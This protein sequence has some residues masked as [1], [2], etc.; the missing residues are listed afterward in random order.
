M[1]EINKEPAIINNINIAD[2]NSIQCEAEADDVIK[3][4]P[5]SSSSLGETETE[6]LEVNLFTE[7]KSLTLEVI[8][9]MYTGRFF[10]FCLMH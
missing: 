7:G 5:K 6:N 10:F 9:F 2:N 8:Y 4:E 1:S 3:I